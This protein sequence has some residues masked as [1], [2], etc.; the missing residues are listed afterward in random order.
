MQETKTVQVSAPST[1]IETPA[2][3]PDGI[4]LTPV[5]M[6]IMAVAMACGSDKNTF[7]RYELK[8]SYEEGSTLQMLV[9]EIR[10]GEGETDAAIERLTQYITLSSGELFEKHQAYMNK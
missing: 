2:V 10:G 7:T 5:F 6:L 4:T 9:V 8:N 3:T 1:W